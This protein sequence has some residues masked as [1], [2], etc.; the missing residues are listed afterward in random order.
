MTT[1]N[2]D[3]LQYPQLKIKKKKRDVDY[4][5]NK[6]RSDLITLLNDNVSSLIITNMSVSDA[7]GQNLYVFRLTDSYVSVIK[8]KG[9]E[10]KKYVMDLTTFNTSLNS[11]PVHPE[12]LFNLIKKINIDIK[13][14]V[15]TTFEETETK[16]ND[17]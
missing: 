3:Q 6:F 11:N 9:L 15:T 8:G 1:I 2:L 5:L 7:D 14:N 13:K 12:I 10:S 17:T 4:Q 16:T